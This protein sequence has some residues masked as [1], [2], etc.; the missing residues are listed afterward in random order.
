MAG[1]FARKLLAANVNGQPLLGEMGDFTPP[2][3]TKTMESARGGKFIPDE[4]MVGIEQMEYSLQIFGATAELLQNYGLSADEVCQVDVKEALEDKDGNKSVVHYSLSGEIK[5]VAEGTVS[6]GSKPEVT[7]SGS[8]FAYKKTQDGKILYDINTKTQ[9]I[10]LGKGDI[11]AE[12][13]RAV[14]LS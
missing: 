8:P 5:T 2:N 4:V 11:M 3:I 14:G 1:Q 6:M 7:I 13:R 10:D 12:H 9:V